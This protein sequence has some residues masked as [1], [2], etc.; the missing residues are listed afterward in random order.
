MNFAEW[1]QG[2]LCSLVLV[3]SGGILL[4]G[5]VSRR[6]RLL[7]VGTLSQ[8]I[9]LALAMQGVFHGRSDL[10]LAAL[11]MTGLGLL[12]SL[13]TGHD[14]PSEGVTPQIASPQSSGEPVESGVQP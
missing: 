12:W 9:I 11:G 14:S 8:G 6:E 7:A 3:V 5:A 13:L 4:V 2:L 1:N 10:T